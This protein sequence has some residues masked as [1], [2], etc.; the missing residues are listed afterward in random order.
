[1][2]G[3]LQAT[4]FDRSTLTDRARKRL[5]LRLGYEEVPGIH[6]SRL[7]GISTGNHRILGTKPDFEQS[8]KADERPVKVFYE[9]PPSANGIPGIHHVMGR[10]IKDY[11]GRYW[12]MQGYRVERKSG[13]DTHG[14]PVEL[15]VE[16]KLGIR[17]DDIGQS[18]SIEEFNRH[19]REDV[20]QYTGKW[21]ELTRL[22]GYWI[23]LDKPY[24][25][26][27]NEYIESVWFLL[28]KLYQ[29]DLLYKGYNIQP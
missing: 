23:D 3:S 17:R 15:Q 6:Q 13:W 22:M 5:F 1:V 29:K 2:D 25:T 26:Y 7:D 16:K 8:L 21:E 4:P 28:Q 14:L 27:H 11:L 18:I 9:G 20:L 10:T 19:C 12:T 24:V